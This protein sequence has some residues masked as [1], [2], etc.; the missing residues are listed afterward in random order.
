MRDT[1]VIAKAADGSY[2]TTSVTFTPMMQV[3]TA[4]PK[5]C[6]SNSGVILTIWADNDSEVQIKP[7]DNGEYIVYLAES[8]NSTEA[9][10][11]KVE[12]ALHCQMLLNDVKIDEETVEVLK[13]GVTVTK[14][15][16]AVLD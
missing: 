15:E 10:K 3:G 14:I 7:N 5:I 9:D 6:D 13:D 2:I 8:D 11:V 1:P 16:Y 4:K 12:S